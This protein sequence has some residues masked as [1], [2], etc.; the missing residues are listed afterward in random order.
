MPE[1][2]RAAVYDDAPTAL[3]LARLARQPH[4]N[5]SV[6]AG[7]ALARYLGS[8]DPVLL[9]DS[10]TSALVLALECLNI[11]PEDE[12]LL[13]TFN[14]PQ[15]I[16]AILAVGAV[17]V[18]IDSDPATGA[19]DPASMVRAVT[20]RTRAI[21]LTHQ[22][23]AVAS[24]TSELVD[25][26]REMSIP[27]VD[28][29]AQ[30]LGASLHGVPAGRLGDVGVLS[31][32]RTKPVNCFGGGAL[33]LTS[34]LQPPRLPPPE[35]TSVGRAA[36]RLRYE[37]FLRSRGSALRRQLSRV[38]APRPLLD[39]VAEALAARPEGVAP[40]TAMAPASAV[41]LRDRV[42]RLS[43]DVLRW[44]HRAETLAELIGDLPV[45]LPPV[46]GE[47]W[48]GASFVLRVAPE[49]R[50][51][52][53]AFLGQHGFQ[54]SWVHYPLHRQRRYA[55]YANQAYPGAE[56]LWRRTLLI[57]CRSLTPTQ[58]VH[59]AASIREYHG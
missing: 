23:G 41:L 3:D 43:R 58:R 51:P 7:H 35:R 5:A 46:R 42:R 25:L 15:V 28:D 19:S 49:H 20:G 24:S 32:G 37:R 1:T 27:V 38:L 56:H 14:C 57:P 29:A 45:G 30:A 47:Q 9:T 36:L 10:G 54:T 48:S 16:D 59:L 44:R 55:R 13:A 40:P 11:G 39:D 4:Q 34:H 8:P 53:G 18:L 21:V 6:A 50:W 33:L 22:F 52:L 2:V 26:A 31:F 12:V 17:P